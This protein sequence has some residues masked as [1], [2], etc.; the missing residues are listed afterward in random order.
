M[1]QILKTPCFYAIWWKTPRTLSLRPCP[2]TSCVTSSRSLYLLGVGGCNDLADGGV[3]VEK[4][5]D[6]VHEVLWKWWSVRWCPWLRVN[7]LSHLWHC[8]KFKHSY[9]MLLGSWT[10]DLG[11]PCKLP[12]DLA[13][14][15][16]NLLLG[17]I[18][19]LPR[20]PP[21]PLHPQRH[22]QY[23]LPSVEISACIS[24]VAIRIVLILGTSESAPFSQALTISHDF[25]NVTLI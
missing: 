18:W 13:P 15:A 14:G 11:W 3:V 12:M 20:S 22:V 17:Q 10:Q 4:L 16:T 19:S 2:P 8:G 23:L 9:A 1:P 25:P 21:S 6:N 24:T 5:R 7:S